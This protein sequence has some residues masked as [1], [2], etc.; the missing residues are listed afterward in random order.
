MQAE[1]LEGLEMKRQAKLAHEEELRKIQAHIE[2]I[3][4]GKLR[5]A[6]DNKKLEVKFEAITTLLMLMTVTVM[7]MVMSL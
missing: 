2:E 4:I 3:R 1:M 7:M 5:T 6:E